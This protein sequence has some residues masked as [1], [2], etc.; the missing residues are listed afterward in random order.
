MTEE[1]PQ[2]DDIVAAL[3]SIAEGIHSLQELGVI[4]SRK[5]VSDYGE[6]IVCQL[7]G[8]RVAKSKTQ[9]GWDVLANDERIQVKTHSK[10]FDNPNRW[11][12]IK[13]GPDDFD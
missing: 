2:I 10:A 4:R 5:F 8:G 7:F 6:W 12:S 11:S 1:N 3:D 9:R 13:G